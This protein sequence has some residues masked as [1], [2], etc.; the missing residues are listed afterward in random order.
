MFYCNLKTFI[1]IRSTTFFPLIWYKQKKIESKYTRVLYVDIS[2]EHV[3]T[4]W[5]NPSLES[6]K[7]S[8]F[9]VISTYNEE[10]RST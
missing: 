3:L 4:G 9:N 8:S 6:L 2:T 1:L 5:R 7:A 10:Y